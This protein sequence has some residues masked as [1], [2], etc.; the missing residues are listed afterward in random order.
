MRFT[1]QLFH[2]REAQYICGFVSHLVSP[3]Q[4]VSVSPVLLDSGVRMFLFLFL[5]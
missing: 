5:D 1:V 4:I 2:Q 3:L